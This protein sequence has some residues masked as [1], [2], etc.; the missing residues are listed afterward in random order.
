MTKLIL[1][2]DSFD[3]QRG[4]GVLHPMPL[5]EEAWGRDLVCANNEIDLGSNGLGP[6]KYALWLADL[7][8]AHKVTRHIAG[9]VILLDP[10]PVNIEEGAGDTLRVKVNE[11]QIFRIVTLIAGKPT[12]NCSLFIF[13]ADPADQTMKVTSD[14]AGRV[15]VLGNPTGHLIQC[16]PE[17]AL[18]IETYGR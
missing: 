2:V 1:T 9:N 3:V 16:E 13:S 4:H 12:P 8:L 6:G 7:E 11:H 10:L 17:I 18:L 14:A 15:L 5:T